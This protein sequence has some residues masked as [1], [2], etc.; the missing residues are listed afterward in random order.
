VCVCVCVSFVTV[1]NVNKLFMECWIEWFELYTYYSD[2][3][4][5]TVHTY[6]SIIVILLG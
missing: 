1:L 4:W 6:S 2:C 5:S 3:V